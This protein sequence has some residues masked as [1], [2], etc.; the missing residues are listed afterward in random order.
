MEVE[1][2]EEG[3][4]DEEDE[5]VGLEEEVEADKEMEIRPSSSQS[6]TDPLLPVI[7]EH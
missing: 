5:E 3:E 2:V 4:E 7:T 1:A 6:V